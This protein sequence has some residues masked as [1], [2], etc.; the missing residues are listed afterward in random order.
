MKD[1]N[2]TPTQVG[3]LLEAINKKIDL[4]TE[5][6]APIPERLSEVEERL[7]KVETRLISVEDVVRIAIPSLSKRVARLEKAGT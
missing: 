5:S 2:F 4:L 6:A 3:T 7:T 1:E